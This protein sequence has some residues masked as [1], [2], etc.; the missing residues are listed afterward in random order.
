MDRGLNKG[1]SAGK[2]RRYYRRCKRNADKEQSPTVLR[3]RNR[4]KPVAQGNGLD[5]PPDAVKRVS[6]V[7]EARL[8]VDYLL[9]FS[10]GYGAVRQSFAFAGI[11]RAGKNV[12][13]FDGMHAVIFP[14]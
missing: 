6:S 5:F 9:R 3:L 7:S 2:I 8:G 14:F 12:L 11:F 4:H 1:D 13:V 10:A